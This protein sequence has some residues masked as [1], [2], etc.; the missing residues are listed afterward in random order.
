MK[1]HLLKCSQKNKNHEMEKHLTA[2]LQEKQSRC[3]WNSCSSGHFDNAETAAT[4]MSSHVTAG[5]VHC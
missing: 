1:S 4:H 3:M 5:A 2:T